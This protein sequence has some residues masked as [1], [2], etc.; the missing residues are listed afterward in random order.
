LPRKRSLIPPAKME[1]GK[2]LLRPQ[3]MAQ[4][5]SCSEAS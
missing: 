4:L 3:L 5:M 1:P 2:R